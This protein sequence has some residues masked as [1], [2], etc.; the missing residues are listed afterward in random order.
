M[1]DPSLHY[2]RL[3]LENCTNARDLGG[4]P[5]MNQKVTKFK[6][7]LRSGNLSYLTQDEI[8]FLKQYGVK[9]VIDLRAEGEAHREPNPFKNMSDIK[10][11]HIPFVVGDITALPYEADNLNAMRDFYTY[12][13]S[14]CAQMIINCIKEIASVDDGI[15]LYHCSAG[16]D[17]TGVL[18]YILLDICGVSEEDI[19]A[20]YQ[21]TETH[22]LPLFKKYAPDFNSIPIQYLRS[23]PKSLEQTIEFIKKNFGNAEGYLLK[24]GV[25]KEDIIKVRQRLLN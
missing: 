22:Y 17:R 4:Y 14:E 1:F 21:I 3:P 5:A 16:K 13:F 18:S 8:D 2:V 15:I 12:M 6:R 11:L 23:E 9:T 25:T 20:N 10:F 7:F 24:H 19:I